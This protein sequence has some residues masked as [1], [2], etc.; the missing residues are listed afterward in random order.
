[1]F[2]SLAVDIFDEKL[3]KAKKMGA[4]VTINSKSEILKEKGKLQLS[5]VYSKSV[6]NDLL[7][8]VFMAT[9]GNGV[10]R[11]IEASGFTPAINSCFELLRFVHFTI[12]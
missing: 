9:E 12:L 4:D 5:G 2:T 6:I 11:L 8:I 7:N 3:E 10:G 1:M